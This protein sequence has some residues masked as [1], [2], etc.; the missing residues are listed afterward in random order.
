MDPIKIKTFIESGELDTDRITDT[1]DIIDQAARALDKACAADIL[2][3]VLFIG[4]DGNVYTV[5]TEACIGL[6]NPDWVKEY[7]DFPEQLDEAL[8]DETK[9]ILEHHV[10][11]QT[12][13]EEL[14]CPV[15]GNNDPD[16]F[17]YWEY[18]AVKRHVRRIE[19]GKVVIEGHYEGSED[20]TEPAFHCGR[21]DHEFPADKIEVGFE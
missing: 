20:D 8:D 11:R 21:C 7:L 12:V 3:C 19:A 6:A 13:P 16:E 4:E 2:G 14:V 15:C 18:Q 9:A 10:K 1:D 17:T 5:T